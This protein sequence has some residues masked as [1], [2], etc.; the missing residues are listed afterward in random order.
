MFRECQRFVFSKE[1]GIG[2]VKSCV[3][4]IRVRC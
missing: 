2:A 4:I 1:V 3:V